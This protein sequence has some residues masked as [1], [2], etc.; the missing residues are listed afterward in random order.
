MYYIF[1]AYKKLDPHD[2][3]IFMAFEDWGI[4][5]LYINVSGVQLVTEI[6]DA[7]QFKP[8]N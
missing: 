1:E 4:N 8:L 7:V 5:F 3:G 2:L 6:G